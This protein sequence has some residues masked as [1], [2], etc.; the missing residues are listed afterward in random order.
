MKYFTLAGSHLTQVLKLWVAGAACNLPSPY[1]VNGR[2]S[3]AAL[4]STDTQ[5]HEACVKGLSYDVIDA[6]V[7]AAFPEFASLCQQCENAKQQARARVLLEETW[8]EHL[9]T[10]AHVEFLCMNVL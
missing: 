3:L 4:L 9:G 6:E 8:L 5:Y 2:L 1:A 7:I 10:L